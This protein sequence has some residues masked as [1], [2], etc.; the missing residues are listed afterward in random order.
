[1]KNK[2]ILLSLM[3]L[4]SCSQKA[5]L[6]GFSC[7]CGRELPIWR[8]KICPDCFD[9]DKRCL[10]MEAQSDILAKY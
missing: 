7:D 6:T 2:I 1:M 4:G 10:T 3:L 9:F 8:N 5:K